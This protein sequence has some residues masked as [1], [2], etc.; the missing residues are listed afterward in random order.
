[1]LGTK[2]ILF[3]FVKILWICM[4]LVVALVGKSIKGCQKYKALR[5]GGGW[6]KARIKEKYKINGGNCR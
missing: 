4:E 2:E 3:L 5:W 1:M 6:G